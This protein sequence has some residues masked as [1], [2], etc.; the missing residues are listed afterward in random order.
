MNSNDLRDRIFGT[1]F[2]QG[3]GDAVGFG[4]EFVSKTKVKCS[5]TT[6]VNQLASGTSSK[7][8]EEL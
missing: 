1:I 3:V 8:N 4:T 5:G 6:R 2:G 7:I